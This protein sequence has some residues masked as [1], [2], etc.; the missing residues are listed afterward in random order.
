MLS[1]SHIQIEPL[2]INV[3]K[4]QSVRAAGQCTWFST[5]WFYTEAPLANG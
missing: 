2:M 5:C 3:M 1:Q 4:S